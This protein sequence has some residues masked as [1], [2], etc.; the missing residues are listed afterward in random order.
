MFIMV[1]FS[2]LAYTYDAIN[3]KPLTFP[4]AQSTPETPLLITGHSGAGK[5]TLLHL[6]AGILRPTRGEV[7]VNG[8]DLS[9]MGQQ[10]MDRFR[11][12]EI[13]LI[14][15]NAHFFPA[16][17]V[18]DNL[19]LAHYFSGRKIDK[20]L[21]LDLAARLHITHLLHK[22]V[23]RISM[24][25]QQRVSIARALVNGPSVLLADEPTSSLDDENCQSVLQL[26][27]EQAQLSNASLIVVT[28]DNRLKPAFSNMIQLS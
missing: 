20:S 17:N 3:W 15:Q 13:G 19:L 4:D 11:G 12:Q 14:F 2:S 9:S 10:R 26:L 23:A 22:P 5:T 8:Q 28:H 6:I 1:R 21:V 7:L 18:M 27:M 24:G 25:E 16:L